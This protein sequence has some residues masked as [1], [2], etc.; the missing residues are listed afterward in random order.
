M[1]VNCPFHHEVTAKLNKNV[2]LVSRLV[3][4]HGGVCDRSDHCPMDGACPF[5]DNSREATRPFIKAC[6]Q[7][8]SWEGRQH[9]EELKR[10]FKAKYERKLT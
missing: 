7:A 1:D 5:H 10:Q 3:T 6:T 4:I 8:A 2:T 9:D